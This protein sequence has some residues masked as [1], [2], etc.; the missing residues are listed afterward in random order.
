MRAVRRRAAGIAAAAIACAGTAGIA[1]VPA[2]AQTPAQ[3]ASGAARY[4]QW[5]V[6]RSASTVSR[7]RSI[8]AG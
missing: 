3:T 7:A 2:Q 6:K 5:N 4:S 8:A 1:A